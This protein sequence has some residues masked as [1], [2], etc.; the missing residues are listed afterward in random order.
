MVLAGSTG[1]CIGIMKSWSC[2]PSFPFDALCPA[3]QENRQEP[4]W[5]VGCKGSASGEGRKLLDAFQSTWHDYVR[6]IKSLSVSSKKILS[7]SF[8]QEI[9][10]LHSLPISKLY[11][12]DLKF[13][14]LSPARE[15]ITA[16]ICIS[17]DFQWKVHRRFHG[18]CCWRCCLRFFSRIQGPPFQKMKCFD[19]INST[20]FRENHK[21]NELEPCIIPAV[22]N[23][24]FIPIQKRIVGIL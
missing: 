23:Q 16:L 22:A 15:F 13:Q 20:T 4:F 2:L 17:K 24:L 11:K 1:W 3:L 8:M 21:W 10:P 18:F 14:C 7:S 5:Y 9:R 19:Y 6:A 12:I